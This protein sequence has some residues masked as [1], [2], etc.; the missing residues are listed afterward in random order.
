MGGGEG[1]DHNKSTS[2]RTFRSSTVE[3][4]KG[5][6]GVAVRNNEG[7]V[8]ASAHTVGRDSWIQ[9]GILLVSSF[10]CGYILTFSNLMLVP[11][12]WAWGLLCLSLI[13]AFA[14]Y[15][16]LLLARFHV[17]DGQRFIR[18]RDLMGFLFGRKMYYLTWVLQFLT[19]LLGNMGF[20]LLGG[21]A[22]KEIN[23]EFSESPMRLQWCVG[24]TGALFFVF[25]V[26]VPTM[27]AMRHWLGASTL[28]AALYIAF[29]FEILARDGRRNKDKD[30]NIIGSRVDKVFNA[31]G[32]I[33]AILVCNTSGLLPEI[34]STIRSPVVKNMRKALYSQYT[35]GLAVYYGVSIVGYWAYGSSVSEYLPQQL[36]G[37]KWV[38]VLINATV[39][40]QSTVS[41][42]MF[43]APIHEAL[44][45]RFLNLEESIYSKENWKRVIILRALFFGAN[46]FVAAMFPFM[47]DFVNLLGSFTLFPLTF[48]FPSMIFIKIKGKEAGRV[49]KIWHWGIILVSSLLA[50]ITTTAAVRL[51][52]NNAR[53][54]HFFAN[55]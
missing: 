8:S 25:G 2:T 26:A 52:V 22:L 14:F 21:R 18:Y 3:I 10:N 42:H 5:G 11:L 28:L 20:I 54:Y 23:S 6:A 29:L 12:G 16:N 24:I 30:Y 40:L 45:T 39:F 41:Q 37:P 49:E 35:L 7:F 4:E 9:V 13:G 50:V 33:S 27:S 36:S 51:I 55:T 48:M 15:A 44:D 38:K 32:A 17:V 31:F 43:V 47:G 46:S 53:V 19:L 1:D 34:Q